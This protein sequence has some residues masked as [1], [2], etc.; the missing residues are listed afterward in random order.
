M[1]TFFH[2]ND[3]TQIPVSSIADIVKCCSD[4]GHEISNIEIEYRNGK[5]WVLALIGDSCICIGYVD[6]MVY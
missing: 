3:Y 6:N 4:V 5:Y 2:P 1:K